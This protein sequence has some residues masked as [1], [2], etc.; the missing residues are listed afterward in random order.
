MEIQ[1]KIKESVV[2][3]VLPTLLG[4]RT[5]EAES[6]FCTWGNNTSRWS[7]ELRA[8]GSANVL[9]CPVENP[10]VLLRKA[11]ASLAA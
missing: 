8:T 3:A 5:I 11:L 1:A 10:A 6:I 4:N 2:R 7:V 9:V